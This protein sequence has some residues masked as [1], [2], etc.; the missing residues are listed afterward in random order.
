MN[1]ETKH[2]ILVIAVCY[3]QWRVDT[4]VH[5][6]VCSVSK[7]LFE[8]V[9]RRFILTDKLYYIEE[10][11]N[12]RNIEG[13]SV[14]FCIIHNIMINILVLE[15]VQCK[16]KQ[17]NLLLAKLNAALSQTSGPFRWVI[18]HPK[19]LTQQNITTLHF[20]FVV[21]SHVSP[22]HAVNSQ[23]VNLK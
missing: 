17:G 14:I 11:N 2:F 8:N 6:W 3:G 21:M 20:S 13:R 18:Y 19:K 22:S 16:I 9:Y 23:Q 15:S 12:L 10:S 7:C 1:L 5:C 4:T